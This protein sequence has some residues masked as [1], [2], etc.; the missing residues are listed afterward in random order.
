[1]KYYGIIKSYDVYEVPKKEICIIL[2]P[3][4]SVLSC[5]ENEYIINVIP[6]KYLLYLLRYAYNTF[7]FV[8]IQNPSFSVVRCNSSD[9][10]WGPFLSYKKRV[11]SKARKEFFVLQIYF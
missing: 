2:D 6:L 5:Q 4:L 11:R 3:M 1:M 10:S 7:Y 9:S 8:N